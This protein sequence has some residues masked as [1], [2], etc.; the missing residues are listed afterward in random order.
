MSTATEQTDRLI[1]FA[2]KQLSRLEK[3]FDG[4]QE[5]GDVDAVHDFRVASRRLQEPLQ[6]VANWTSRRATGRAEKRLKRL[7]RALREVRDLDVLFESLREPGTA[8]ELSDCDRDRLEHLLIDRRRRKLAK[9]RAR[10]LDRKPHKVQE[11]VTE[12]IGV[13][14][15]RTADEREAVIDA[16][17]AQWRQRAEAVLAQHPAD[18]AS[19]DLHECRILLKKLRYTT[20]LLRRMEERKKGALIDALTTMQDVLGAWN[21]DQFAVRALAGC[22]TQEKTLGRSARFSGAV[23]KCAAE[24]AAHAEG[25]RREALAAWPELRRAIEAECTER[26]QPLAV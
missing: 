24:R 11:Q 18:D 9:A 10:L 5:Q 7:R 23:L 6:V 17:N 13:F 19:T 22:A 16:V 21:D 20:E 25:K 14:R 4:V 8:P 1:E 3:H 2:N 26:S 15:T 12:L